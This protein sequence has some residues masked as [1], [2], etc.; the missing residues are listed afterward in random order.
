MKIRYSRE[1]FTIEAKRQNLPLVLSDKCPECGEEVKHDYSKMCYM[2]YIVL[3]VPMS[4]AFWCGECNHSW[5]C[6]IQLNLSV[7]KCPAP[8]EEDSDADQT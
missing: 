5:E 4:V 8:D 3:N 6:W 1:A 7:K 2:S